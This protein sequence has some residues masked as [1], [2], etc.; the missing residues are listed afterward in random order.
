MILNSL[1]CV[2]RG[3]LDDNISSREWDMKYIVEIGDGKDLTER[4][5]QL[6]FSCYTDGSMKDNIAGVG[7]LILNKNAEFCKISYTSY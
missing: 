7:A 3:A 6:S 4:Q 1:P 2:P 5:R